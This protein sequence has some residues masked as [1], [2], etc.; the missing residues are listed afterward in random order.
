MQS[1]GLE[2]VLMNLNINQYKLLKLLEKKSNFM[3]TESI[4]EGS[5]SY[6][7]SDYNLEKYTH[8]IIAE[9]SVSDIEHLKAKSLL[10]EDKI[11]SNMNLNL[12][13]YKMVELTATAYNTFKI[14]TAGI[15]LT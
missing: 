1:E 3:L 14:V 2:K 12:K 7:L 5:V 13:Y 4:S 8:S 11:T 10:R 15:K 6:H 9:C